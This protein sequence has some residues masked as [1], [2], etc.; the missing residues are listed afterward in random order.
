MTKNTASGLTLCSDNT[1]ILKYIRLFLEELI[2]SILS[3]EKVEK[4]R[5][6]FKHDW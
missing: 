6:A 4:R 1:F 2:P 3:V 5:G